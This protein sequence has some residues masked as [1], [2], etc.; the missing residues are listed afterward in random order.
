MTNRCSNTIDI[1]WPI[2]DV[3]KIHSYIKKTWF[4]NSFHPRPKKKDRYDRNCIHRGTKRDVFK[5]DFYW[6][7]L[8]VNETSFK[9]ELHLALDTARSPPIEAMQYLAKKHDKVNIN[10]RY[11]EWGMSF[12]WDISRTNGELSYHEERDDP[13]RWD[14]KE[15]EICHCIYDGDRDE[16]RGNNEMTICQNCRDDRLPA[17]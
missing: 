2:D 3:K 15:C 5:Q 7:D 16:D 8:D 17:K 1:D 13:Y 9:A 6:L 11:S 10:M 14:G 12:S 4:F